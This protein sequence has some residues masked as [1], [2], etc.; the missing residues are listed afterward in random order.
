MNTKRI[1]RC[2]TFNQEM[3]SDDERD[4]I[5]L[6]GE[7]EEWSLPS[8]KQ[9]YQSFVAYILN[10]SNQ[11]PPPPTQKSMNLSLYNNILLPNLDEIEKDRRNN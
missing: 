4:G 8:E 5:L 2:R 1:M 9:H 10:Q 6:S 7:D 11:T 3:E